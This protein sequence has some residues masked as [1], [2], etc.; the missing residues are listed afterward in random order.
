MA[1]GQS[2]EIISI[3]QWIRTSRLSTKKS[4]SQ[5]RQGKA[6]VVIQARQR[7]RAGRTAAELR[8]QVQPYTLIP[9][10]ST[11]NPIP[12]NLRGNRCGHLW[13]DKRT[14]LNTYGVISGPR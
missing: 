13:R 10:P 6:A 2:T 9:D 4:L 1:Q 5:V 14:V 11:L 7:G 12:P 8:A 3:I